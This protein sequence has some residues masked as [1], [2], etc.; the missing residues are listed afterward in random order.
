MLVPL[1]I[2]ENRYPAECRM[3]ELKNINYA[4]MIE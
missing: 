2:Q 1:N 3:L 4:L